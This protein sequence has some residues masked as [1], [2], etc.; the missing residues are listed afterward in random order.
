MTMKFN[1]RLCAWGSALVL[2][3][4]LVSVGSTAYADPGHGKAVGKDQQSSSSQDAGGQGANAQCPGGPYCANG[5]GS[6]SQNGNGGGKATGKPCAGC[7]GKADDK[8]PK[9]Q[10][11][12]GSDPNK[13]YECDQNNGIGKTNPAHTGCT[14]DEPT[15]TPTP[16]P[17]PA[18]VPTVTP[19]PEPTPTAA[20][21]TPTVEVLGKQRSRDPQVLPNTGAPA[22]LALV[23]ALGLVLVA[24]GVAI[25]RKVSAAPSAGSRRA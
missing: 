23:G 10:L 17:T 16:S 9:G 25:L 13:G 15:P 1:V 4:A 19:T 5:D 24:A 8:N 18:P 12:G 11:P 20:T 14:Q 7:V 6:P 21:P 22:G 3:A 2:G